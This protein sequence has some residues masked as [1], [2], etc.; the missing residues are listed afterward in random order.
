MGGD[1]D[2]DD[3]GIEVPSDVGSMLV[4]ARAVLGLRDPR[5]SLFDDDDPCLAAFLLFLLLLVVG[6]VDA[7][8]CLI[9]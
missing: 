9:L 4:V 5:L 1:E 2:E 6:C 8:L 7:E 3:S